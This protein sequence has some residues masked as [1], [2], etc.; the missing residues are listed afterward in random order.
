MISE[1]GGLSGIAPGFDV[2]VGKRSLFCSEVE[3]WRERLMVFTIVNHPSSLAAG[4]VSH[5]S[6]T[7]IPNSS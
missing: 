1:I 7:L 2:G 6:P 5:F 4:G 3:T